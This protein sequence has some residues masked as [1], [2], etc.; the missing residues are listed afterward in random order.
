MAAAAQPPRPER[1]PH[2]EPLRKKVSSWSCG[3]AAPPPR[4][5]SRHEVS[6][7]IGTAPF[8]G[9]ATAK[10]YSQHLVVEDVARGG[11]LRGAGVL[12]VR[13]QRHERVT[14]RLPRK[15]WSAIEPDLSR[16]RQPRRQPLRRPRL[17][18]AAA[19][20]RP[21]IAASREHHRHVRQAVAGAVVAE[22]G[23]GDARNVIDEPSAGRHSGA[24]D[25]ELYGRCSCFAP[26]WQS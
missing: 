1:P 23:D 2:L 10:G 8:G 12:R 5:S 20:G 11:V 21:A 13:L 25:C 22:R 17:S 14:Q 24:V 7:V 3:S 6:Q 26:S 9:G 16:R 4:M 18:A 15:A 19:P